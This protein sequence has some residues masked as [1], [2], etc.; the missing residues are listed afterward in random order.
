MRM[1]TNGAVIQTSDSSFEKAGFNI[2]INQHAFKVLSSGLYSNKIRAVIREISCNAWDSH[3]EA[4]NTDRPFDLTLPNR[5]NSTFRVRDYGVGLSKDD[6]KNVYTSYFTSTK[7]DTNDMT[8]CFGLGSKSPFAYTKKFTVVSFF[9]GKRYHF[10][11]IINEQGFPEVVLVATTST[12]EHNGLEV[13]FSVPNSYDHS[14]FVEEAAYVLRSFP[15]ESFSVSGYP[16]FKVT[17]EGVTPFLEGAGWRLH[18]GTGSARA[19]MGNVEYPLEIKDGFSPDAQ[20]V[21]RDSNIEIDFPLGSFEVTPSRETIQW[22]D[23]SVANIN[24]RLEKVAE[25][26]ISVAVQSLASAKSLWEAHKQA[27]A[28]A[29]SPGLRGFKMQSRCVWRGKKVGGVI[30]LPNKLT[31]SDDFRFRSYHSQ[32]SGRARHGRTCKVSNSFELSPS[33]C[34][35]IF[36]DDIKTSNAR[37]EYYIRT[38]P[39]TDGSVYLLTVS[40]NKVFKAFLKATGFPVD[41]LRRASELPLE[42]RST[43]AGSSSAPVAKKKSKA[44]YLEPSGSEL[45]DYWKGANIDVKGATGTNLYIEIRNWRSTVARP[46]LNRWQEVESKKSRSPDSL[47]TLMSNLKALDLVDKDAKLLGVR[48]AGLSKFKKAKNWTNLYDFVPEALLNKVT[49][50]KELFYAYDFYYG[51]LSRDFERSTALS[52]YKKVYLP[53]KDDLDPSSHLLKVGR[54]IEVLSRH[55][56]KV[57]NLRYLLPYASEKFSLVTR[58]IPEGSYGRYR[59]PDEKKMKECR[60]LRNVPLYYPLLSHLLNEDVK[61]EQLL[62]Y[63]QAMDVYNTQQKQSKK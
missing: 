61:S 39:S 32:Y 34:G 15:K 48:T 56:K 43:A 25:D 45:R 42:D 53:L 50:D 5:L 54:A 28:L 11:A 35:E 24:E 1:P 46:G 14:R 9:N 7:Q 49:S 51:E 16:N 55:E 44:F 27:T 60:Y 20:A 31:A 22:S 12:D 37:V 3:V 47:N 2:Q 13:S 36:L 8:G 57:D 52:F 29:R 40:T 33:H 6:V 23:F 30:H 17:G 63:I 21:L 19:F 26:V 10:N 58:R 62:V 41:K 18:K 4:G 59:M 38:R